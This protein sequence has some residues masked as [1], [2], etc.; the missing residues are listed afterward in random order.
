MWD[1]TYFGELAK[2]GETV[3][4]FKH[5]YKYFIAKTCDITISRFQGQGCAF[6]YVSAPSSLS[7]CL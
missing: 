4:R 5:H 3:C 1:Q 7:R 2:L 6:C